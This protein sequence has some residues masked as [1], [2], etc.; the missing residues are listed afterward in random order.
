[1]KC[2]I[3][4]ILL[5]LLFLT[6]MASAQ[7]YS[8]FDV[9]L[10][11]N[12]SISFNK[13]EIKSF[14][15]PY[16]RFNHEND[17]PLSYRNYQV[18]SGYHF[19]RTHSIRIRYDLLRVGFKLTGDYVYLGWQGS[20]PYYLENS[21]SEYLLHSIGLNYEFTTKKIIPLIIGF[22]AAYQWNNSDQDQRV[23]FDGIYLNNWAAN[24]YLGTSYQSTDNLALV[25]K[26]LG[27]NAFDNKNKEVVIS[28]RVSKYVPIT[29]AGEISVRIT[30]E[31][32]SNIKPKTDAPSS[33]TF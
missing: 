25:F 12:R 32:K 27:I 14:E 31:E 2:K 23:Q 13:E 11:L 10:G 4:C 24:L 33:Q 9:E 17:E 20:G 26:L 7:W 21:S 30:I 29:L 18:S 5:P 3:Y 6:S 22:G 8:N 15:T 16:I 1:M 19:N 28:N